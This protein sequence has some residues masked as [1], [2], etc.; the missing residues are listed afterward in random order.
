MNLQYGRTAANTLCST[1]Y[2]VNFE[3]LKERHRQESNPTTYTGN[4]RP[5]PLHYHDYC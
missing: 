4:T 3:D 5:S 2:C 1:S